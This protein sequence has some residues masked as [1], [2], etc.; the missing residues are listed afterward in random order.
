MG[1]AAPDPN[2]RMLV[3]AQDPA[4]ALSAALVPAM[5]CTGAAESAGDGGGR[6]SLPASSTGRVLVWRVGMRA[7]P[8]RRPNDTKP[9]A[10]GQISRDRPMAEP[11]RRPRKRLRA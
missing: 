2:S 1:P 6:A 8:P 7:L 10:Q 3:P 11:V 9:S 5:A 4:F